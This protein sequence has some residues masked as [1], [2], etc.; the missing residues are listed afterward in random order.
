MGTEL[1]DADFATAKQEALRWIK[2]QGW[3]HDA[4]LKLIMD[5]IEAMTAWHQP[6]TSA[7]TYERVRTAIINVS[8][9]MSNKHVHS[10]EHA[11]DKYDTEILRIQIDL[12]IV[13]AMQ[14]NHKIPES[15]EDHPW[16]D[17]EVFYLS[18]HWYVSMQEEILYMLDNTFPKINLVWI[19]Q[20]VSSRLKC[21]DDDL[22]D[23]VDNPKSR[24]LL[25]A[26][27]AIKAKNETPPKETTQDEAPKETTKRS[28]EFMSDKGDNRHDKP[29]K[30]V[31]R[32]QDSTQPTYEELEKML[33]EA[34]KEAEI[35]KDLA[36]THRKNKIMYKKAIRVMKKRLLDSNVKY[37]KYKR[38]T[39][40]LSEIVSSAITSY[41]G[42]L[43]EE[44]HN[45]IDE[46]DGEE[47]E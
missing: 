43:R 10:I 36:N 9:Y 34:R 26:L 1:S 22:H 32:A 46:E 33:A 41:Q 15:L 31:T 12:L 16:D 25:N 27:T 5:E 23:N 47:D 13:M 37:K 4:W 38:M 24:E 20:L 21:H 40:K 44:D 11:L 39:G 42:I 28:I 29:S 19:E 8:A 14:L 2:S 3:I 45:G 7:I 35:N 18:Y 30:E 6:V 17:A